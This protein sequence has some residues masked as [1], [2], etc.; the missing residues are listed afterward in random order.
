MKNDVISTLRYRKMFCAKFVFPVV[1]IVSSGLVEPIKLQKIP[2]L[3][4]ADRPV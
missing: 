4:R 3:N 2:C 1:L